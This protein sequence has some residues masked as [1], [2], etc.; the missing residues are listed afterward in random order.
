MCQR[1]WIHDLLTD[2][3]NLLLQNILQFRPGNRD[4]ALLMACSS[5]FMAVNVERMSNSGV[6]ADDGKMTLA[7]TSLKY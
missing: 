1:V 7:H 6:M 4:I 3:A 2:F 5:T